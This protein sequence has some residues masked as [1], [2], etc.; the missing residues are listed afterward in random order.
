MIKRAAF[1]FLIL[2]FTIRLHAQLSAEF[3]TD[4]LTANTFVSSSFISDH[5]GWLADDAGNLWHTADGGTSWTSY[6]TEI[7]FLNID[8]TDAM[9]GFGLTSEAAYKTF[10][11]GNTWSLLTLSGTTGKSLNF[12]DA[13][14]GFISGNEVIYK[15]TDGGQSW[16]SISNEGINFLDYFFMDENTGVAA[17][18]DTDSTRSIMRTTD[19]G[20]QWNHVYAAEDFFINAVWVTNENTAWAAGY[21]ASTARGNYPAIIRSTDGGVTWENTYLNRETGNRKGERF[22][23]IRFRNELEGYAL[24]AYSESVYTIDGGQTWNFLYDESGTCFVPDWG[25]YQVL[26]GV[27][28]LYLLGRNGYVTKWK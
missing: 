14:T 11:G 23:D 25:I 1:L 7:N 17:V 5:E 18:Y 21:Y 20:L 24:S 9:N 13:S 10:D 6:P 19:G 3:E 22:V 2:L 27:H 16:T 15:T 12:L 26:A 8:F 28:D 4:S